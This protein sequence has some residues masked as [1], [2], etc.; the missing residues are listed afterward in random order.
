MKSKPFALLI[1]SFLLFSGLSQAQNV[2]RQVP[3]TNDVMMRQADSVKE[4]MSRQ[5]FVVVKEASMTMESEYEMPV[6]VPLNEGS[7]YQFVFIGDISSKLYE[8]RMY[9]WNE[10]QVAYEKKMW[11]DVDGNVISFSYIPKFSEYHMMKPVQVNKRKKNELCGY[12]M[13]LKKVQQ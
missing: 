7:W 5:G 4:I 3:C 13:L 9:D 2:I 11:G 1:C 12:V 8:V 6:I 10:K